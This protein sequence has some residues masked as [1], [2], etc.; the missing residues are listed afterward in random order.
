MALNPKPD[1]RTIAVIK[2][3][4]AANPAAYLLGRLLRIKRPQTIE[5]VNGYTTQAEAITVLMQVSH[6]NREAMAFKLGISVSMLD[7]ASS[8]TIGGT[9]HI[10]T[11]ERAETLAKLCNLPK[12]VKFF[13]VLHTHYRKNSKMGAV[14]NPSTEWWDEDPYGKKRREM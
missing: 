9:F 6:L 13:H 11:L 14:R 5:P 2:A 7:K 3:V 12:M 8:G 1:A 4:Q 10:S